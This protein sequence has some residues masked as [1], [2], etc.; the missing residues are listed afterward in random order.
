MSSRIRNECPV[1]WAEFDDSQQNCVLWVYF[2]F[3]YP[4]E[5]FH[6]TEVQVPLI[7]TYKVTKEAKSS[8]GEGYIFCYESTIG[9]TSVV[10]LQY[11]LVLYSEYQVLSKVP[12]TVE[13][14]I[15]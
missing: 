2:L 11:L 6:A 14:D 3:I 5:I 8:H 4:L 1:A 12:G 7:P 9:T 13:I 10:L 15:R